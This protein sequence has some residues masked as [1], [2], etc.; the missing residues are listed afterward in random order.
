VACLEEQ[1]RRIRLRLQARIR[2]TA[3]AGSLSGSGVTVPS[4][5]QHCAFG[6]AGGK[7]AFSCL[8]AGK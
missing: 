4:N 3:E 5:E 2:G 8:L 6:S 7:A 1:L